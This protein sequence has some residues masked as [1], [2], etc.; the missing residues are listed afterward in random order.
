MVWRGSRFG[1]ILLFATLWTGALQTP[2][3]MGFSRQEYW[4]ELPCTPPGDL[5][6]PGIKGKHIL[7]LLHWEPGSLPL[8]H[9]GSRLDGMIIT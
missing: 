2:L 4:S 3:S 8:S 6:H 9:L 5:P 1:C 7:R